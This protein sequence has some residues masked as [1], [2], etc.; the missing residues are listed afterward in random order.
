MATQKIRINS[1]D[2][3]DFAGTLPSDFTIE[4]PTKMQGTYQ[5][6]WIYMPLMYLNI[7]PNN[8]R[9]YFTEN[10]EQKTAFIPQGIYS[11][12]TMLKDAVATAMNYAS[13]GVNT[14]TTAYNTLERLL[15]ITSDTIDF[16]LNFDNMECSA[17]EILGFVPQYQTSVDRSIGGDH[18]FNLSTL[19][20]INI[21]INSI[22]SIS[23]TNA[24][25]DPTFTMP[26]L[27][28]IGTVQFY[29]PPVNLPE[30]CQIPNNT[31]SL[32]IRVIDDNNQIIPIQHEWH[33]ILKRVYK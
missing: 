22:S 10:E 12:A 23:D 1:C 6:H 24:V 7:N 2:R 3:V 21:D 11:G 5:L 30:Y 27:S 31:T 17:A 33:M 29:T 28:N 26:I 32:R 14:Y 20:V 9:I 4:L 16:A 19:Q 13:N 15:T 18:S 8:N 25:A